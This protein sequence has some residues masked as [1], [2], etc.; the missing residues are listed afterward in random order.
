MWL[1]GF[2]AH[3]CRIAVALG[4][5]PLA[6]PRLRCSGTCLS[7][8]LAR[9]ALGSSRSRFGFS[10]ESLESLAR[11]PC[12]FSGLLALVLAN[13][14]SK[15]YTSVEKRWREKGVGRSH[16]AAPSRSATSR[17]APASI[18]PVGFETPIRDPSQPGLV[19]SRLDTSGLDWMLVLWKLPTGRIEAAAS[20][21]GIPFYD[22]APVLG[23]T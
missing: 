14:Q 21:P 11:A 22:P 8:P 16:M 15:V 9:A 19:V 12:V 2:H 7:S 6:L 10:E 20:A 1:R 13:P 23:S 4:A 5:H 18:D 3:W 17:P